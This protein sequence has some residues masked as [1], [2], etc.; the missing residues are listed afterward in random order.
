MNGSKQTMFYCF[1]NSPDEIFIGASFLARA[2]AVPPPLLYS[3][4]N[5]S[6]VRSL[7][8][9]SVMQGPAKLVL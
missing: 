2:A 4:Y 3:K 6:K 8:G 1:L 7:T 9:Y 5:V